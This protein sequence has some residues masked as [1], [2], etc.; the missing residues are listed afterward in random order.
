MFSQPQTVSIVVNTLNR[1][2]SL[3][4][5]LESFRWLD[6]DPFEVVVVNGP[7]IDDTEA[8]LDEYGGAIKR[9]RCPL[10]NLSMSR[11]IGISLATGDVVGFIDDD[12]IPEPE[13]LTQAMAAFDSEDVGAVGGR[14]F[15]PSGYSFQYEYTTADRLGNAN[16]RR[17][18]A[19]PEYCFPLSREFP[20]LQ[21]TNA[22]F[23]RDVLVAVGGFDE[24]IEYYL[25]ETD[26][27]LRIVDAGYLIRQMPDAY[28]HHKFA[29]S[30]IRG[31]NRIARYRYPV[32]K[33]KVYFAL[34]NRR[35][36]Y[37][38]QDVALDRA[39]FM[40]GQRADVDFHAKAGR[41]SQADRQKLDVDIE[42]GT[43]CAEMA[44]AL[45]RKLLRVSEASA[46]HA[47]FCRF[48]RGLPE[49]NDRL[50]LAFTSR[51]YPPNH[52]GGVAR[53]VKELAESCAARGHTVHILTQSAVHS[54]VDF[55]SGV[56]VH[57]IALA[58]HQ[59]SE[60]A[61]CLKI[62][63][64]IWDYSATMLAELDRISTHRR[65]DVIQVPIWD[66][67]GIAILLS[68]RYRLFVSLQTTLALSLETHPE[69]ERDEKFME[70]F[71]RPMVVLERMLIEKSAGIHAISAAIK[72]S[73]EGAYKLDIPPS[74]FGVAHLGF[75]DW[76]TESDILQAT[77]TA[78]DH[79]TT[80]LY[81]GR[82]EIRKG[83][84]VLLD[85]IPELCE[86]NPTLKFVL[87]GDNSILVSDGM[88]LRQRFEAGNPSLVGKRVEFLGRVTD[89]AL[90]GLYRDCDIFVAPSRFE[91]FGLIYL[92]AM[93]F[94][95]P[96]IGCRV[97]GIPEV[98]E[99][100]V[101]GLLVAPGRR[102]DLVWALKTLVSDRDRRRA[103]GQAGRQRYLEQFTD[104]AMTSQY[105][106][107]VRRS[108]GMHQT[109]D[110]T[111]HICGERIDGE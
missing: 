21:G 44:A 108:V 66:C 85:C 82:L 15:D 88:T 78:H 95:K 58:S 72:S 57:R 18:K 77:R 111:T 50:T 47:M 8:V 67:E 5:T 73:V 91:S 107:L 105:L 48:A 19:T 39:Q 74:R 55:E 27:C 98:V 104:L 29:P 25:D 99:D 81:V 32:I 60:E 31:E 70:Q 13:W 12:A 52:L 76:C 65:V 45:P 100:G 92:E 49:A 96:V 53:F 36:Y 4:K 59:T 6:F 14:V 54:T 2:E 33:N 11:N 90:R 102:A 7:S 106:R 16:W 10:A 62:P 42:S 41:L 101:T 71:F 35:Q 84:D 109:L 1:A 89:D 40:D 22:L 64:H 51:D 37:S 97:G 86:W 87:A 110:Q 28:V 93:M 68:R 9:G 61:S 38:D 3:R 24:E 103:M 26:V 80:V 46:D 34:V 17:V 83:A 43:K 23:R 63:Q 20:Y 75:K 94:G 56:W 30:H 69:W 79:Q